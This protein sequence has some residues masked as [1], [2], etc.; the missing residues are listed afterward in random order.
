MFVLYLYFQTIDWFC[1]LF[2]TF[3]AFTTTVVCVLVLVVGGNMNK[4]H[5]ERMGGLNVL[6]DAIY[7]SNMSTMS[8][9]ETTTETVDTTDTPETTETP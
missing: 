1:F 9:T 2:F 5:L 8:T 3:L 6:E 7:N 4:P